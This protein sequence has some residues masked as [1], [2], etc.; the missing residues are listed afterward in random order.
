MISF[1]QV[2][3]SYS[4]KPTIKNL[5]FELKEGHITALVGPNGAGKSTIMKLLSTYLEPDSGIISVFGENS[6]LNPKKVIN[7]VGFLSDDF[8]LY[9]KLSIMQNLD[10]FAQSR[11]IDK[12]KRN[13]RCQQLI[14]DLELS[15]LSSHKVMELSK[16]QRQRVA[17]AQSMIHHP[18][19][20][21][22]DEPAAGLDP[23][24]RLSLSQFFLKLKNQYNMT[25]LVSSH[26]L[27]ELEDYSDDLLIIEDGEFHSFDSIAKKSSKK[28]KLKIKFEGD[29]DVVD[30]FIRKKFKE[31]EIQI[32]NKSA[33]IYFEGSRKR[34][35]LL[36][37]EFVDEGIEISGFHV[38]TEKLKD[39]YLRNINKKKTLKGENDDS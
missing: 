25:L 4:K 38:V 13:E 24:T 34:V 20:L 10:Y 29:V 17:I 8:G 15:K 6:F 19:L 9:P 23:A 37:K 1:D 12:E 3:F 11:G 27:S 31:F 14:D 30:A 22:L 35:P 36:L 33:D 7:Q 26:I 21:I 16:G 5:S 39:V 18:K 2:N 32:E 28:L